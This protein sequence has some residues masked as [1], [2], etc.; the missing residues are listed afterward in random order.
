MLQLEVEFLIVQ[1]K[2]TNNVGVDPSE[3]IIFIVSDLGYY[4][5][6]FQNIH[7]NAIYKISS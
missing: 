3:E 1:H 7:V 6:V 4:I 5:I 2:N